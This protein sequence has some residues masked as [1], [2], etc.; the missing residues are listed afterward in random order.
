MLPKGTAHRSA[1]H[2]SLERISTNASP[3]R[4][5]C[6][7]EELAG[8]KDKIAIEFGWKDGPQIFQ[9]DAINAQLQMHD[10]LVHAGTGM[11]KTGIA[12][13]PH[14]HPSA[15][16]KVTLMVSPLIALHDEMVS[17]NLK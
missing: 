15:K 5:P 2:R 16:G 1:R 8:L 9:M 17:N 7:L 10:V 13:G 3:S 11:G 14:L 12:A 6:T 4:K